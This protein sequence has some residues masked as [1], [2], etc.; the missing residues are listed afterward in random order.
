[1]KRL[2]LDLDDEL[3][4]ELRV[5]AATLGVPMSD[6][7]R[8]LLRDYLAAPARRQEQVE[9]AARQLGTSQDER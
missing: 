7:C 6:L 5:R 9:K 2:T 3:H 8:A 1:M 4:R